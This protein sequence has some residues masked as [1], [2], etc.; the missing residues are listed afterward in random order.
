V[1]IKKNIVCISA[2][3]SAARAGNYLAYRLQLIQG[4]ELDYRLFS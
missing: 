3:G 4:I 1:I 2:A